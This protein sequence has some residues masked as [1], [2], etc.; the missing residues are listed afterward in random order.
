VEPRNEDGSSSFFL[1]P[2]ADLVNHAEDPNAQ[3]SGARTLTP[4]LQRGCMRGRE[5][6]GGNGNGYYYGTAAAPPRSRDA[7]RVLWAGA[8]NGTHVLM[9]ALRD[10]KEGEEVTNNYQPNVIHRPDMAMHV[11]GERPG[12]VVVVDSPM[13]TPMHAGVGSLVCPVYL[14]SPVL[15]SAHL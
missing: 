15:Q 11:Y 5:H 9:H 7:R 1:I 12:F 8:D 10:I 14:F 3:R 6:A 2:V 13:H 4:P